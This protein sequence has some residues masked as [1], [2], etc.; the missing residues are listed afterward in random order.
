LET[1]FSKGKKEA[2]SMGSKYTHKLSM[3]FSPENALAAIQVIR[4]PSSLLKKINIFL[5]HFMSP[6]ETCKV[7]NTAHYVRDA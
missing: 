4:F 6:K 3:A 5:D 7:G 2:A 1:T